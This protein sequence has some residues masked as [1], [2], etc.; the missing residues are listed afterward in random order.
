M[1][2]YYKLLGVLPNATTEEIK[3]AY[4]QLALKYHPDRNPDDKSSEAFF[5]RVT[6]AYSI[7]SNPE[8]REKYNY[9]NKSNQ[10]APD[11]SSQQQKGNEQYEPRM[12]PQD[13]LS[14]FQK[15]RNEV[16]GVHPS[17]INQAALYDSLNSSLSH[18]N[19]KFLLACGDANINQQ[20]INEVIIC[21][22]FLAYPHVENLSLKLV[23]LAG[24]DGNAIGKI[25]SFTEQQK[26][27]NYWKK[28]KGIA[29]VMAA[30]FFFAII[31]NEGD[32]SSSVYSSNQYNRPTDGDLNNTFI[33]DLEASK[34]SKSTEQNASHNT[35]LTY[36]QKLQQEKEKLIAEGW[37][38]TDVNNGQLPSCYNF[39]PKKSK[40][41]NYLEVHV[42]G[43]TDV[44][45]K[46]MNLYTDKCIRYV[47][48]N[49][50]ST[51]K[52]RNIP[53]GTYYLKIA[54]GKDWF[55]KVEGGKC[56]GKFIR[57]PMYEKGKDIMDFNLKYTSDGYSIPSFQL[58]LDV[59]STNKMN[60]FSSQNI[61]E[62]EFNE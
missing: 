32:N 12:S 20:I 55:S 34:S 27:W 14:V 23:N 6:E 8:K 4:R 16:K 47:F 22:K 30:L 24:S 54:Y 59:I 19:I 1:T 40:I 42:G 7:L 50:G 57:N 37:E 26:Y 36:E 48:I 10:N 31:S 60:T 62:N 43:G 44:A 18:N 9:E 21:C 45:I 49:S 53:E 35:E 41:D 61:S 46:V 13:F 11:D 2:D 56:V 38:E 3:K 29:I 15:I 5:K 33:E 39:I 17:R 52:I 28:Y 25:L 51:Y 58:E